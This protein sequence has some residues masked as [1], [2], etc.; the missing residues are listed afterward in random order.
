MM[1][2]KRSG[3]LVLCLGL[4]SSD[5]FSQ[6]ARHSIRWGIPPTAWLLFAHAATLPSLSPKKSDGRK[7]TD[8]KKNNAKNN[9][10]RARKQSS[11]NKRNVTQQKEQKGAT[12][13]LGSSSNIKILHDPCE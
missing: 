11:L 10:V 8:T 5:V 4:A 2:K 6:G 3:A 13:S 1:E 7:L 12:A 9:V